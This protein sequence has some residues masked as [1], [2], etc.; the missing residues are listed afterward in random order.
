MCRQAGIHFA[1]QSFTLFLSSALAHRTCTHFAFQSF[2]HLRTH[3]SP[4]WDTLC[5]AK[6]HSFSVFR[7]RTPHLHTFCQA[8]KHSA[9]QSFTLF[10]APAPVHVCV[11]RL[12]YMKGR[13]CVPAWSTVCTCATKRSVP[14]FVLFCTWLRVCGVCG[15]ECESVSV[16][17]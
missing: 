12:G 17:V 13:M 14:S 3:V 16:C 4:G 1:S 6:L 7:T 9:T 15:C 10:N 5:I 11:A 2:P 8:E